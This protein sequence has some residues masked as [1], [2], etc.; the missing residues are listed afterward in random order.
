MVALSAMG[1]GNRKQP[2]IIAAKPRG[3]I[4]PPV[5]NLRNPVAPSS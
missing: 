2:G 5:W 4:P 1:G 3:M